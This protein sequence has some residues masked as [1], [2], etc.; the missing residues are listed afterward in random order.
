MNNK[1]ISILGC[2]W[3]GLPLAEFLI[4]K[5]YTVKGSTTSQT[6]EETLKERNIIPFVFKLGE[7]CDKTLMNDFFS[8]SEVIVI[9][10]PPKRIPNIFNV[11]QEQIKE[12]LPYIKPE[13]KVIFISSTSV[14]QNTNDWVT[15]T[16]D[17]K[18]EKESGKAVLAV[19]QLLQS[20]LKNN[21]TILR[22]AGLV[23]YD[24]VPGRFLAKKKEVANGKAPINV[25]HQDDCIGLINAIISEN[26]WGTIINGCADE[27]PLRETFYTLAA[28]KE[29]LIPPEFKASDS[30]EFKKISNTKSKTLLKYNYKYPDPLILVS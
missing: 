18:P 14:Y 15:E 20:R 26:A 12:V 5:G 3:L 29:G 2:G 4:D 10:F 16:L 1:Q 17:N 9:N 23:G 22:L 27:H 7:S 11:Y 8:D 13:Q 30:I 25:I 28:E 6:K 19:E 24:R 21:L